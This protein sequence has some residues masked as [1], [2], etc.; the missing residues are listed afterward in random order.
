[1][2][3]NINTGTQQDIEGIKDL[4]VD[5]ETERFMFKTMF[6]AIPD[7]VFCKDTELN[8]TRCNESFL[9][10]FNLTEADVI[11]KDDEK[12]LG[13]PEE[14]ARQFQATDLAV[15]SDRKVYKCEEYVPTAG[16]DVRLFETNKV[17]LLLHGE[18]IGIMG[19][20]RDI[21]ERKAME[22]AAQ[23]AN[24]AKSDF[25]SA[26]SHEI[27]TPMNA[28]L[29]V[30]EIQLQNEDLDPGVREALDRIYFSGDLLLGIINDI[31][32]LSKIEV[33]RLELLV[34]KYEIA[35]LVSDTAQIN[36]MRIGSKLIDF[37]LEVDERLPK[38]LLGDE[39]R[40]KQILNNLLSNAF[41]YTARGTVVL[42]VSAEKSQKNENEVILVITVSDTGQG[43]TKEQLGKLFDEY[44]RFN[45]VVNRET[46]GT[47]LGMSITNKLINLMKGD[48]TV[49][50]EPDVGSTFTVRLP[51]KLVNPDVLGKE[52]VEN[53]QHFRTSSRAQM[54]KVH[55]Q[56]EPMPY[57]KVL[58]VDD[59]ETNIYVAKGL[60]TPYA[61]KIDSAGSGAETINKIKSGKTYDIIFMDQMMPVMDGIET[62]RR[63]RALGYDRPI[64]ALTA[65]AVAGQAEVFLS[66]GFDAYI[67]KPIDLRHLNLV[68]NKLIR[69][70]QP[71]EVVE[72]ARQEA[73]AKK[74]LAQGSQGDGAA[75]VTVQEGAS[76]TKA[77][78]AGLDISKGLELVNGNEKEYIKILRSYVANMREML[79]SA[80]NVS[81]DR[82]ADY[83]ITVHGVKGTSYSIFAKLIGE[84]AEALE[85]AAS[86]GDYDYVCE[87][88][89]TFLETAWKLTGD[90]DGM[91]LAYDKEHP[92]P[93]KDSPDKS[94][95]SDLLTSCQRFD[96]DGID[97]AMEDIEM[98]EYESDDGLVSW[99]RETV[100]VMDLAQVV[101]RLT[102][103]GV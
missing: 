85:K 26:M 54:S 45:Q 49:E 71:P 102:N 56:R 77:E 35:S 62:T 69:D 36:M 12:G 19:I 72:A 51:Q 74:A 100:N 82:L 67:S 27:R 75:Q 103:L 61:L 31:L 9:R 81:L 73:M 87:F 7:L 6:D 68:L 60:M 44:T 34:A 80:E 95:L 65:N 4:L 91:I 20:A 13:V 90:L 3:F 76:V 42:S 79:A 10:Y 28:I 94:A 40:I 70:N 23:S 21:T 29:G 33:G 30:T 84:L 46:E 14:T 53:L 98:Y 41:K 47:G 16:G 24:K 55:I 57:G 11:G 59:V 15:I 48:I 101:T 25:L 64:V 63:L 88:N 96:M 92:K 83:K 22:E 99:L 78:V 52:M 39:L 97:E 1:L 50:S 32:D 43:M 8:Y 38:Q 66:S 93:K 2:E 17:P 86:A 5:L 58:I 89:P 37:E 18:I